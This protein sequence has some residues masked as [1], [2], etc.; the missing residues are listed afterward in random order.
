MMIRTWITDQPL[1]MADVIAAV[2]TPA[3]GA[4][5]MFAGTVREQNDGRPV[6][7]MRYDAYT[8]MAE[9]VLREIAR[10]AAGRWDVSA[11]AA[12][13][14]TGE[15][16][17]GDVAIAIAVSS[18][19]RAEAFDAGRYIIEETKRRLP[20]WKQERYTDAPSRWLEGV[21]PPAPEPAP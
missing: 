5:L 14:R 1:A 11:I 3:D 17:I 13:H 8:E 21:T 18:P 15:L 10:E 20:V 7:G 6:T 12:A 4:V 16:I 9:R 2:G 19:H